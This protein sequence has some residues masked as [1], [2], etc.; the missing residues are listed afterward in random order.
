MPSVVDIDTLREYKKRFN[1]FETPEPLAAKMGEFLSHMGRDIR[2][3]EPSAGLGALIRAAERGCDFPPT[4]D[5]CE[6]QEEFCLMLGKYNRVGGDFEKYNPGPVYDAVIMNP[7]YKNGLA[8]RHVDH[9]W[10]CIKPGGRI[11]ILVGKGSVDFIDRE[12]EGH[13]FYREKIKKGFKETSIDT[14]L[15][16]IHKPLWA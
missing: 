9:A 12:F 8:N 15:Y 16:L 13:V 11:V 5:Y 7:P 14:F 1:F 2:I 4:I 10:S 6:I 3:L